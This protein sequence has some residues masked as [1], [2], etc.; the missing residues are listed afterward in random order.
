MNF[1]SILGVIAAAAVLA[2]SILTSTKNPKVFA[3]VHGIVIVIGG[4]LTVA[5]LSFRFK[6]LIAALKIIIRKMF[7]KGKV[8]YL[9]TIKDIVTLSEVYRTEPKRALETLPQTSHPFIRDGV[10]LMV[11]YGFNIEELEA[12]LNN[13]VKGKKKRDDEEVKVWHTVARF[14]PA[15]G[16]LGA[17]LGMIALLQTL[18]EPGAQDRI[19]PAMATALVATF[20]GIA[21]ANLLLIPIGENLAEVGA[22]DHVLRN[23][24][25]EGLLMVHEKRHPVFI[26]EYLKSFLPPSQR[27]AELGAGGGDSGKSGKT[28]VAA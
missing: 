2:F 12:I 22:T 21:C 1:S 5:L 6:R 17:V 25:K 19:G 20:Y 9:G 26:E 18:G 27:E 7:G 15:F 4:T 8:D 28:N 3:D 16:L 24:I 11:E 13:A 23:I 14:P 10:K